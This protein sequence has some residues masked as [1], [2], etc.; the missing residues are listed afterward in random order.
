MTDLETAKKEYGEGTRL[1]QAGQV[2][3]ALPHLKAAAEAY[4]TAQTLT[5]LTWGLMQMG[6][7]AQAIAYFQVMA[8]N[9]WHSARTLTLCSQAYEGVAQFDDAIATY[10]RAIDLDPVFGPALRRFCDLMWPRDPDEVIRRLDSAYAQ[11]D[12]ETPD[13]IE[14]LKYVATYHERTARRAAGKS[15]LFGETLEDLSFTY[16]LD[17]R[18]RAVEVADAVLARDPDNRGALSLLAS[19]CLRQ[20]RWDDVTDYL[21][22]VEDEPR[23]HA[24]HMVW[25]DAPRARRLDALTPEDVFATFAPCETLVALPPSD[26][27]TVFLS[28][29]PDYFAQFTAPFLL[30]LEATGAPARVQVHMINAKQNDLAIAEAFLSGLTGIACG[31]STELATNLEGHGVSMRNYAH[32]IR[33]IRAN[34]LLI[35]SNGPVCMTDV[36]ALVNRDPQGIFERVRGGDLGLWAVPGVWRTNSHFCAALTVF[37][38]T[39]NGR[40]FLAR[41]AA[42][43]ADAF[44]R[45]EFFWGLDQNALYVVYDEMLRD[46][47]APDITCIDESLLS[48]TSDPGA[49][50][51]GDSGKEKFELVRR[52]MTEDVDPQSLGDDPYAQTYAS[53]FL[54]AQ[55][56][57]KATA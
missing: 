48:L 44:Q 49:V 3:A 35:D 29:T 32:A 8:D 2:D 46:G 38:P 1:M 56:A 42:Y 37:N 30:S 11:I 28:S 33:Y 41:V 22:G 26:A 40:H 20:R 18:D 34:A 23:H 51:W 21:K 54:K 39:D 16:A 5:A 4:P 25:M 13:C 55:N 43:I 12:A 19:H 27:G 52:L 36:D 15:D 14:M 24:E 10:R 57:F 50:L 6:D 7:Y 9:N 17:K 45:S 53:Y 31:L 47:R